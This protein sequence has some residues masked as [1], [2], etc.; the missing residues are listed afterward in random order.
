MHPTRC[1]LSPLFPGRNGVDGQGAGDVRGRRL[2]TGSGLQRGRGLRAPY[3][4][5]IFRQEYSPARLLKEGLRVAPDIF[6]AALKLPLLVSEGLTMIEERTRRKPQR[7]SDGRPRDTLWGRV[8]GGGRHPDRTRGSLAP[9][10]RY[11]V[12]GR[13]A[14]P[15][16]AWR[17]K[18]ILNFQFSIRNSRP[19][20][21]LISDFHHPSPQRTG[22]AGGNSKFKTK[23]AKF[24]TFL[25]SFSPHFA[26][27]LPRSDIRTLDFLNDKW[28]RAGK[29]PQP[30]GV[31]SVLEYHTTRGL[32]SSS[33]T[34][35]RQMNETERPYQRNREPRSVSRWR[36]ASSSSQCWWLVPFLG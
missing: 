18:K 32:R 29:R 21:P 31:S 34:G 12:H 17:V 6:D 13:C 8:H 7:P 27:G 30:F 33:S 28:N 16:E 2:S 19:P 14:A 22:G 24:K 36:S 20:I 15:T 23:S 26:P 25:A 4:A 11:A 3:T 35:G 10:R 5:L 1:P 9:W